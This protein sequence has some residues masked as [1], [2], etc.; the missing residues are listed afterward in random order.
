MYLEYLVRICA[1]AETY[2]GGRPVGSLRPEAIGSPVQGTTG[3]LGSTETKAGQFQPNK[4]R[5]A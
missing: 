5:G 1:C 4:R 3:H 2:R